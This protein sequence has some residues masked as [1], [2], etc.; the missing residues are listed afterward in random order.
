MLQLQAGNH[1]DFPMVCD[2]M[3]ITKDS[4]LHLLDAIVIGLLCTNSNSSNDNSR[5]Y[6]VVEFENSTTTVYDSLE[7]KQ[8]LTQA[9]A[10]SLR[11]CGVLLYIGSYRPPTLRSEE[12]DQVASVTSRVQR[13]ETPSKVAGRLRIQK[14]RNAYSNGL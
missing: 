11:V 5:H 13:R 1:D 10:Q 7:G 4:G 3:H 14:T 8:K 12:L 6:W 2:S 9:L